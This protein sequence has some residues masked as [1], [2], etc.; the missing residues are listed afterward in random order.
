[1]FETLIESGSRR[2]TP[3]PGSAVS[4]AVHAG[5]IALAVAGTWNHR[6]DPVAV[7]DT[8]LVELPV[9]SAT[10]AQPDL[11]SQPEAS[12]AGDFSASFTALVPDFVTIDFAVP[13]NPVANPGIDLRH[14]IAQQLGNPVLGLPGVAPGSSTLGSGVH[15]VGEVDEP[16][17][18]VRAGVLRYPAALEAAGIAG[19]VAL[20]FVVDT[21]GLVSRR[22]CG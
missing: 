22:R 17:S 7:R 9:W 6:P 15:L 4:L 14:S 10:P 16:A 3:A 11:P 1:M 21:L 13:V 20:E 18:I 2:S 8:T 5:L 12:S 19:R